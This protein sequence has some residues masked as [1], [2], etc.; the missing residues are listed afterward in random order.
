MTSITEMAKRDL[1]IVGRADLPAKVSLYS[2]TYNILVGI[3][4]LAH[5]KVDSV[6]LE[7][8]NSGIYNEELRSTVLDACDKF[9]SNI[10]DDDWVPQSPISDLLRDRKL[11]ELSKSLKHNDY[12]DVDI[13]RELLRRRFNEEQ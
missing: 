5:T 8:N 4:A 3:Y 6:I 9:Y 10:E 12:L 1:S 13:L 7:W 11:P 2:L